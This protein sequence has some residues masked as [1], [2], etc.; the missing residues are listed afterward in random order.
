[1]SALS[2]SARH[3]SPQTPSFQLFPI[4]HQHLPNCHRAPQRGAISCSGNTRNAIAKTLRK[5]FLPSNP[6]YQARS[7][8][9]P[10]FI[11]RYP[12][13]WPL[14]CICLYVQVNVCV[15]ESPARWICRQGHMEKGQLS[16]LPPYGCELTG[17]TDG[18]LYDFVLSAQDPL[19][20]QALEIRP[21]P[22]QFATLH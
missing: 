4:A 9:T 18:W 13:S 17:L 1:M 6:L 14:D 7:S 3:P 10:S 21:E 8:Q 22:D 15:Y 11:E 5:N 19:C 12:P 2:S 20:G 16:R